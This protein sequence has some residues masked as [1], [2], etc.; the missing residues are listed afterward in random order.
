MTREK[1]I[2]MLPCYVTGDLDPDVA[3][4]IDHIVESDPE[5]ARLADQLREQNERIAAA[6]AVE[7]PAA[8][9]A[10][11]PVE[12]AEPVAQARPEGRAPVGALVM[13]AI[14]LAAAI[15]LAVMLA[16]R[17]GPDDA[18]VASIPSVVYTHEVAFMGQLTA[19]DPADEAAVARGFEAAGVPTALRHVADLSDIGLT[20]RAV[21]VIPGQPPGTAVAYA[22]ADFDAL[23]Q[24]WL[25]LS[26]PPRSAV[27]RRVGDL[28][29]H[30]FVADDVSLVM[31]SDGPVL[32]VMT[33]EV[34]LDELI[35]LVERRV[36]AA[37]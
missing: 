3:V 24:M 8:L 7:P 29:L 14:A 19:L 37:G 2:D 22:G 12:A 30:G 11:W 27:Q 5:V 33:A 10:E 1:A 34:P 4:E 28:E 26:I 23:C 6:L 21:Y 35:A 17:L 16:W 36:S 18:T 13:S 25:G 31:W 9:F 20:T 15:A 32:C